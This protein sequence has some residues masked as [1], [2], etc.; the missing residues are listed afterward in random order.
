MENSEVGIAVSEKR[1]AWFMDTCLKFQNLGAS[2]DDAG[3][4]AIRVLR[5]A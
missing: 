2:P 1:A 3:K 4:E 5:D